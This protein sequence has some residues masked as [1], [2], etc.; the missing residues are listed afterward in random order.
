MRVYPYFDSDCNLHRAS[1]RKTMLN[2]RARST[3]VSLSRQHAVPLRYVYTKRS[4]C[5]YNNQNPK[6]DA[7]NELTCCRALC[8]AAIYGP[9]VRATCELLRIPLA[10]IAVCSRTMT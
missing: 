2:V 4:M 7:A 5:I 6:Q 1:I 9:R 3:P 8:R 10:P